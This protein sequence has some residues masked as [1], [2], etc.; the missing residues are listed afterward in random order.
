MRCPWRRASIK[1]S[2]GEITRYGRRCMWE[3][4]HIGPHEVPRRAKQ[5]SD[6]VWFNP[7][8]GDSLTQHD[9]EVGI[10]Q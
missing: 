7:D 2:H 1:N 9:P 3:E 6:G 8:T 5:A 4:G 10:R